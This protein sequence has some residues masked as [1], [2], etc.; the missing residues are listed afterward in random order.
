MVDQ[1]NP[2]KQKEK[3]LGSL[4]SVKNQTILLIKSYGVSEIWEIEFFVSINAIVRGYKLNFF[5]F[6][7]F[8]QTAPKQMKETKHKLPI[9]ETF[10]SNGQRP[11]VG[12]LIATKNKNKN[13]T[14]L[15]LF[16]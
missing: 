12:K 5:L 10:S 1:A 8:F 7:L 6:V 13:K 3:K 16:D 15:P 11:R 14:K 9:W 4:K 2:K